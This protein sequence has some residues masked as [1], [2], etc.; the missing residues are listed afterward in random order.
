MPFKVSAR[1]ILQLGGELISSDGIAFY[2][3]IKNS[4][5]ARANRA[6]VEIVIR[7]PN[8]VW[9][10]A[11]DRIDAC[12]EANSSLEELESLKSTLV[13]AAI[14]SRISDDWLHELDAAES[15]ACFRSVVWDALLRFRA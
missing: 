7:L 3:L 8:D 2:E 4:F 11:V 10:D 1:T 13:E 14:P 6:I 12:V 9:V 15:V 5:D